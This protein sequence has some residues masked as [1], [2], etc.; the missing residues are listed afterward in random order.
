[1]QLLK[2]VWTFKGVTLLPMLKKLPTSWK[3][4][5]PG[6]EKNPEGCD[7]FPRGGRQ[8]PGLWRRDSLLQ[9]AIWFS[10]PETRGFLKC[11]VH[12]NT[13]KNSQ[14]NAGRQ[15]AV[16]P[17]SSHSQNKSD[18]LVKNRPGYELQV[19]NHTRIPADDDSGRMVLVQELWEFKSNL[20]TTKGPSSTTR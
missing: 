1:M 12:R 6:P 15:Y 8:Q 14:A 16:F 9:R 11:L 18:L 7:F 3:K 2:K 20:S 5:P 10:Q 13:W 17:R 19:D 4:D